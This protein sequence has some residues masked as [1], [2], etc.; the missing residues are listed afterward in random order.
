MKKTKEKPVINLKELIH[1]M[2]RDSVF[3]KEVAQEKK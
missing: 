2:N 1:K 3:K